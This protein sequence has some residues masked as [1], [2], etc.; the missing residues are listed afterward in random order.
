MP[1]FMNERCYLIVQPGFRVINH[2]L[3]HLKKEQ[4]GEEDEH[5]QETE[6]ICQFSVLECC[7]FPPRD[8]EMY[9]LKIYRE[10]IVKRQKR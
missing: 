6:D 2:W 10:E 8:D 9:N 3:Y 7:M 5:K 4:N 1:L